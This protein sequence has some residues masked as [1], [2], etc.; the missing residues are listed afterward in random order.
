MG[1]QDLSQMKLAVLLMLLL[2]SWRAFALPTSWLP[3]KG[4]VPSLESI[5]NFNHSTQL[6]GP[7][8]TISQYAV[9]LLTKQPITSD[10]F[11]AIFERTER[12]TP[13][14]ILSLLRKHQPFVYGAFEF[15]VVAANIIFAAG[16]ATFLLRV[17][18]T[19]GSSKEQD[20][21]VNFKLLLNTYM[22]SSWVV[23][24]IAI[25]FAVIV[26]SCDFNINM[27][28]QALTVFIT[29][30]KNNLY[31]FID[32]DMLA[33]ADKTYNGLMEEIQEHEKFFTM[34]FATTAGVA[35]VAALREY[36]QMP[37][38]FKANYTKA[39]SEVVPPATS[40][41][42]VEKAAAA[43]DTATKEMSAAVLTA[44]LD[45][46]VFQRYGLIITLSDLIERVRGQLTSYKHEV[47]NV[48]T[49][50][51]S[52][53]S[54]LLDD[55]QTLFYIPTMQKGISQTI[56]L[57]LIFV[58]TTIGGMI[59][60]CLLGYTNHPDNTSP[61]ERNELSNV[62]GKILV[63]TSYIMTA[64][65]TIMTLVTG[66]VLVVGC[67]A[68]IFMCR[69]DRSFGENP[70]LIDYSSLLLMN[71][72]KNS[73]DVRKVIRFSVVQ[74]HCQSHL[75][76]S[77]LAGIRT[78]ELGKAVRKIAGLQKDLTYHYTLNV[79]DL[80]R[81]LGERQKLVEDFYK[82]FTAANIKATPDN[83]VQMDLI[84]AYITD[85]NKLFQYSN[86]STEDLKKFLEKA[87]IQF[88]LKKCDSV[89]ND[90][91]LRLSDFD[92]VGNCSKLLGVYEVCFTIFCK[93]L[94]D[95]VN[96]YWLSLLCMVCVY[97]YAIYI[98]LCTSKYFFTMESYTYE[99]EPVPE[100]MKQAAD[101]PEGIDYGQ[102]DEEQRRMKEA[103]EKAKALRKMKV[104]RIE[105]AREQ[106]EGNIRGALMAMVPLAPLRVVA[107][108]IVK[109]RDQP[110][111]SQG[112]SE[113]LSS[114]TS[115]APL[116]TQQNQASSQPGSKNYSPN[117]KKY[118][119][120]ELAP[121]FRP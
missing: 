23:M 96:G 11:R 22:V 116:G 15:T 107:A 118:P 114:Q 36:K 88:T 9:F 103:A 19:C 100:G 30:Y 46:T 27:G 56:T 40:L 65:V 5:L 62:A 120:D 80:V 14:V 21:T 24:G 91:T 13:S 95:Y 104:T 84:Q 68:E 12:A 28:A 108:K 74:A 53:F 52:M 67:L 60:G 99:G 110:G 89:R 35:L 7:W 58:G 34:D 81:R 70:L 42:A 32:R 102:A 117:D 33:E 29:S 4:V 82:A 98:C 49:G 64:G 112:T 54:I 20:V 76:I 69:V 43:V 77:E 115:P 105:E 85:D 51:E 57:M 66:L 17:I 25:F 3:D 111:S 59:C 1:R 47:G 48:R 18:G 106:K 86:K 119:A 113:T 93:G 26:L 39:L 55:P 75:G 63:I 16:V 101:V 2:C 78:E 45:S 61:L 37:T 10:F 90:I 94:I 72:M 41:P 73:Y 92:S 44:L 109:G 50:V 71:P 87:F 6:I 79:R 8:V 83:K 38:I 121:V 97:I 31:D